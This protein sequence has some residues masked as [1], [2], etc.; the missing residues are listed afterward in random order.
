MLL[1]EPLVLEL[2]SSAAAAAVPV[3]RT[4]REHRDA[5]ARAPAASVRSSHF[6]VGRVRA[7]VG[8]CSRS[9][10]SALACRDRRC[11]VWIA[12]RPPAISFWGRANRE[13]SKMST[14]TLD[15]ELLKALQDESSLPRAVRG[16]ASTLVDKLQETL[17]GTARRGLCRARH[18]FR[19][20]TRG[21]PS[22]APRDARTPARPESSDAN[23]LIFENRL[24]S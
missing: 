1:T 18:D 8:R 17:S 16:V 20:S 9:A 14:G 12:T 13:L 22:S 7:D 6:R 23:T 5:Q 3:S 21:E 4:A 15:A 2:I 11:G 24:S 10:V 19:Q